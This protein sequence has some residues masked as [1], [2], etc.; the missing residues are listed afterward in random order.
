M[1]IWPPSSR[2]RPS[3]PI[4]TPTTK[5]R[6]QTLCDSYEREETLRADFASSLGED[7]EFDDHASC[8]GMAIF[9]SGGKASKR[10]TPRHGSGSLFSS[11]TTPAASHQ[12]PHQQQQLQPTQ[13]GQSHRAQSTNTFSPAGGFAPEKTG[14]NS[15]PLTLLSMDTAAGKPPS[16]RGGYAEKG[17]L[18]DQVRGYDFGRWLVFFRPPR[19]C[20]AKRSHADAHVARRG[21][22][23][24]DRA[25]YGVRSCY[26]S[27][28]FTHVFF[29]LVW[30][31]VGLS[32]SR[33]V[34]SSAKLEMISWC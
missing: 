14:D 11:S 24:A 18:L 15:P 27:V 2:L 32:L 16:G 33:L 1:P 34:S 26:L 3:R 22:P 21:Q 8:L 12:L 31:G 4:T 28:D 9:T 10:T 23:P 7:D 5:Q 29:V 13:R 25:A 6:R 19:A 30:V 17:C 20:Q